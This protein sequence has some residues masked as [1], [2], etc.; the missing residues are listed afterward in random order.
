[1]V[2]VSALA[3]AGAHMILFTTGR[4]TP[5]GGPVPTVKLST[6]TELARRKPA[7]ID[8]DAGVLLEGRPMPELVDELFAYC[9]DIASGRRRTRN[10]DN[11]FREIAIFK[12]GVT[13]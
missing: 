10:E 8:F 3:A 2:S 4:G 6:T 1:M 13:V 12:D 7:W 11:D 9:L 5:L